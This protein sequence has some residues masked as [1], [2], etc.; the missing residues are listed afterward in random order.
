MADRIGSKRRYITGFDGLRA[1]A[2]IGVIIFHL[3]PNVML[4]GWLGVPLFF[5]LSGYLITDILIQEF[6]K[7]G[8]IHFGSF[9]LRRVKRLYPA[10]V[11]MLLATATAIAFFARPL[12]YNL[13]AIILTNL[14]Y[15]YNLWATVH[16]D[17]YFDQWGGASPFTHLWSL[18]IEGQFYLVWPLVVWLL[19]KLKVPRVRVAQGLMGLALVSAILMAVYYNP[20][21]IN[22]AYYGTDTRLFAILIGTALAFVW[23]SGKLNMRAKRQ[24]RRLLNYAGFL[25]MAILVILFFALNGQWTGTYYGFMF[26]ATIDIAV[27][28]GVTAHP[29]TLLSHW[30]DNR[31][32]NYIGT[33]SYSIYLYQLPVFVFV[34]IWTKHTNSLASGLGK[35]VI[36]L[37]LAELSYQ[38]IER[39]FKRYYGVENI[40]NFDS[41]RIYTA[42]VMMMAVM[43]TSGVLTPQASGP[44]P[45]TKLEQ[46]LSKNKKILATQ[47]AKA[48]SAQKAAQKATS[49]KAD[50]T[51]S[52]SSSAAKGAIEVAG[53]ATSAVARKYNL[54]DA[55][56]QAVKS[57]AVTAIGD[58]V[59][60]DAG[61]SLQELMPGTTVDGQVGRQPNEAVTIVQ[62]MAAKGTLAQN[63]LMVIGTNGAISPEQVQTVLDAAGSHRQVYWVGVSADRAWINGNNSVLVATQ[64][65]HAN[66]HLIDWPDAVKAHPEWLGE[67][68]VHPDVQGSIQYASLIAQK[69]AEN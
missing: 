40:F 50:E 66:L 36:V 31:L 46:R 5:V 34:D 15:V 60:L 20:T 2:V 33:R 9:Y 69:I 68:K 29:A 12:L 45:T 32:L 21:N 55:Q 30:L 41:V 61:P 65:K 1:I 18:S 62:Q 22:R 17:S 52:K 35:I 56:Y 6:E 16:G 13:R 49:S 64:K 4:G 53:G 51:S 54:T 39:V 44:K 3:W 57:K 67:D 25:A 19:L 8:T 11:V 7:T 59:L 24:T 58:S 28:I 10:L 23:P 43:A 48:L 26:L 14:T 27:I 63:L 38:F 42:F 47:N 37:V